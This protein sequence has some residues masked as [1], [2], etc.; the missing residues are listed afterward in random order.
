MPGQSSHKLV[1]FGADA[2]P[3]DGQT[4]LLLL[5]GINGDQSPAKWPG[6]LDAAI[7]K[8][9]AASPISGAMRVVAPSYLDLLASGDGGESPEPPRTSRPDEA[10]RQRD[11]LNYFVR[12][13]ELW[14]RMRSAEEALTWPGDKRGLW[15]NLGSAEA[16]ALLTPMLKQVRHYRGSP[17]LR[18]AVISRVLPELD[19]C[20]RWVIVGHSLGSVVALDLLTHLPDGIEVPALVTVASP[21]SRGILASHVKKLRDRFPHGRVGVW[22]NAFNP[23]DAV[24]GGAGVAK[25]FPE[26][27]DIVVPGA[28]TDH[29]AEHCLVNPAVA[30][31]VGRGL[32]GSPST[33]LVVPERSV[34]PAWQSVDLLTAAR[35]QLAFRVQEF[36]HVHKEG[37]LT[38]DRWRAARRLLVGEIGRGEHL[39]ALDALPDLLA[40]L[41]ADIRG[42]LHATDASSLL[43]YLVTVNPISP[44]AIDVDEE[45]M[46]DSVRATV[47]D[48]GLPPA[49]A[50]VAWVAYA[51]ARDSYK[52]GLARVPRGLWPALAV[53][54]L[55]M[56][57]AAPY[58]VIAVAPAG[59]AGAAAITG[60]LAALGPGGMMGGLMVVG[61]MASVGSIGAAVGTMAPVLAAQSPDQVRQSC[62]ELMSRAV[63]DSKL[64][65]VAHPG[66]LEWRILSSIAGHLTVEHA[67]HEAVSDDDAPAVKDIRR[68][69]GYVQ[70][71]IDWLVAR[72][73]G[74]AEIDGV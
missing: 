28:F 50:D 49:H 1:R 68:K 32:F 57:I 13:A 64:Q 47:S 35:L 19:A 25:R 14:H 30:D 74:P 39:G 31:V 45:L 65:L 12:Q 46:K 11:R 60:G 8:L 10:T 24:P 16:S 59:L 48:L 70:H 44:F 3:P 29:S 56:L 41:S 15:P 61:A 38:L 66:E 4:G 72:G 17:E 33:E 20:S 62:I 54:G 5:H 7:A 22:I 43:T 23:G 6:V 67:Q 27:V 21:L 2:A 52:S 58:A 9:R 51:A 36:L 53:A 26:A 73:L 34:V 40:D 69:L 18:H 42:R 63:V 55:G 37:T 71:A